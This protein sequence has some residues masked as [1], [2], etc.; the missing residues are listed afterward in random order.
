MEMKMGM[1]DMV[2]ALTSEKPGRNQILRGSNVRTIPIQRNSPAS[3]LEERRWIELDSDRTTNQS[4]EKL[5]KTP[6]VS[7]HRH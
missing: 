5:R 7:V 4:G 2:R 6:I 1:G 3:E